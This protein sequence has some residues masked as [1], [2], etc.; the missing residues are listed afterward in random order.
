MI[1]INT[2]NFIKKYILLLSF[3]CKIN[4]IK[5]KLIYN[6]LDYLKGILNNLMTN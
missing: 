6:M 4:L 1:M 2:K 5:Q 3:K